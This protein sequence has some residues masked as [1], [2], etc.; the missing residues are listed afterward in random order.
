MDMPQVDWPTTADDLDKWVGLVA[1]HPLWDRAVADPERE[2]VRQRPRNGAF[3]PYEKEYRRKD[4]SCYPVMV[5]GNH[6]VDPYG[7]EIGWAIVQDISERRAME[8]E[9]A[10]ATQRGW[11]R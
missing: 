10:E 2:A 11:R 3:G 9:L 7:R 4:G 8:Q 6:H 1:R 5:S